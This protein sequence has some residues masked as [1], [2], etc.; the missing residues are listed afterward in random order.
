[1][2]NNYHHGTGEINLTYLKSKQRYLLRTISSKAFLKC[3]ILSFYGSVKE[4]IVCGL[5]RVVPKCLYT[6]TNIRHIT[7]LMNVDGTSYCLKGVSLLAGGIKAT[8]QSQQL[9]FAV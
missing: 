7:T 1:M 2:W 3:E 8:K 4:A 6:V 5:L 9:S